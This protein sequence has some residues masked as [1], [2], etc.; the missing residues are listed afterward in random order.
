MIAYRQ[1]Y[2]DLIDVHAKKLTL[3]DTV[4]IFLEAVQIVTVVL[5]LA[6][7][8]ESSVGVTIVL[9]LLWALCVL[10]VVLPSVTARMEDRRAKLYG[11]TS[12]PSTPI[13]A[14]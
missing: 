13:M 2:V 6:S 5:G 11:Q 3:L 4:C 10:G 9:L 14:T 1:P 8:E 7:T 12:A